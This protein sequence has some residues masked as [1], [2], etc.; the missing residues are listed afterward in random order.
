[1][2]AVFSESFVRPDQLLMRETTATAIALLTVLVG[3]CASPPGTTASTGNEAAMDVVSGAVSE[4]TATR[5]VVELETADWADEM[6]Y[7]A[8]FQDREGWLESEGWLVGRSVP[9]TTPVTTVIFEDV[10]AVPTAVSAFIDIARDE[11]LTRNGL[12][13]PVEPWGFSNDLSVLFGK[14][15][16]RSARVTVE[17]PETVVRFAIGTGLDR[18]AIRRARRE[19]EAASRES[20]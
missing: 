1:M 7:V 10:P 19:A 9:V 14:P 2:S 3:G 16:F 17:P 8:L 18:S 11:N 12:G 13:I 4:V 15:S 5:L 20:S 6:C